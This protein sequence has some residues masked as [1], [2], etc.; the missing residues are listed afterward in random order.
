MLR[1]G[2]YALRGRDRA[3]LSSHTPQGSGCQKR[4]NSR[5]CPTPVPLAHMQM[6]GTALASTRRRVAPCPRPQ[7]AQTPDAHVRCRQIRSPITSLRVHSSPAQRLTRHANPLRS[8]Y[9]ERITRHREGV[10]IAKL[11]HRLPFGHPERDVMCGS[12]RGHDDLALNLPNVLVEH[13][14]LGE[15]ALLHH[16]LHC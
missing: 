14:G 1:C 12:S 9:S 10:V 11:A 16:E 15:L 5:A 4:A 7:W 13:V 8:L 3:V 2:F 6:H